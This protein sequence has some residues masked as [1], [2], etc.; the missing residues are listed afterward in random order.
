MQIIAC[1]LL[2]EI[3]TLYI[4]IKDSWKEDAGKKQRFIAGLAL[5][6]HQTVFFFGEFF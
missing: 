6:T 4:F 3:L 5:K 1:F 2:T